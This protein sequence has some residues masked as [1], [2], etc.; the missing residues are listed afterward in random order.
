MAKV[1]GPYFPKGRVEDL[2]FYEMGGEHIVR[3]WT[4]LTGERVKTDPAFALTMVYAGIQAN[5]ST[6]SSRVYREL[7]DERRI[8]SFYKILKSLAY[9]LLKQGFTAEETY[10]L[11][12]NAALTRE[13][14]A[15][16]TDHTEEKGN[17]HADAY[18]AHEGKGL[19]KKHVGV[20]VA[21]KCFADALLESLFAGTEEFLVYER[22]IVLGDTPP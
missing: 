7:P 4:S 3:E 9:R 6:I 15:A 2:L 17:Q 1:V 12:H 16:E 19:V 18:S 10:T 11:L 5:A 21:D 20:G 22:D 13:D 14:V 8:Y